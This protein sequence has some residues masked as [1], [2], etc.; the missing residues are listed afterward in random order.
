MKH[1]SAIKFSSARADFFT[2]LNHRVN[3]YFKSNNISRYANAQMK[4]KTVFMFALYAVPYY[5][6]VSQTVANGWGMLALCIL[7][8]TGIAGIGLAVMHDANHGSYSNK[9]WINN[10]VGY[11]LNVMG[12]GAFN[13]KVQHNVLHHTYTNIH[14]VDEDISPRGILRMTPHSEWKSIHRFQHIYA[15]FVYGLM[16]LVWVLIKDFVRLSRYH[17]DGLVT[18]QKAD[19]KKEW[20]ILIATKLIYVGYILVIPMMVLDIT[21]WQW[22]IGFVAMHYVAGFI[23]AIIFQPA[24]VIDGTEFPMPDDNGKMDNSWAIHQLH[25]TTNFANNSTLFSWYVGGLNFQVEHHLFPNVCHVHYKKIS[26][27]VRATTEEFGLPYKSERRFI[28]A[29]VGHGKLLKELGKRPVLQIN[30]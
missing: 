5:L 22:L 8:G 3:D 9:S 20:A 23:L 2:T 29:I 4:F 6:I 26:T 14:D 27:I 11:S 25:T 1:S 24:H 17:K 18:K 15:W 13:W 16:T 10:L 19:I 7:M 30:R 21:W 28:D 12:A